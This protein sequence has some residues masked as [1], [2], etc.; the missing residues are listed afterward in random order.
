MKLTN[1]SEL[2]TIRAERI[3]KEK[4]AAAAIFEGALASVDEII[5]ARADRGMTSYSWEV[6]SV[7]RYNPFWDKEQSKAVFTDAGYT[8]R[9]VENCAVGRLWWDIG[10]VL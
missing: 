4:L 2:T 7:L 5:R 6:P 9:E 10:W 8:I 3:R 1:A